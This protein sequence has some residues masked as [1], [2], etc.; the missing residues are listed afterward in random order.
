MDEIWKYAFV[1]SA[2]INVC[3][4]IMELWSR[5]LVSDLEKIARDSL[6]MNDRLLK[7]EWNRLTE[8]ELIPEEELPRW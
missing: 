3:L 7:K 4:I 1:A 5:K 8:E 2:L 6:A